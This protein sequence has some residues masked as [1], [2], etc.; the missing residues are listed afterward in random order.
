VVLGASGCTGGG[1]GPVDPPLPQSS[2]SSTASSLQRSPVASPSGTAE[3]Q[4]LSQYRRFWI[5]T[6]R[7]AFAAPSSRRA[8]VLQPVVADPLR[9]ELLRL[10]AAQ[11]RLLRTSTG[12]PRL[13]R[14]VVSRNGGEAVVFGCL[15]MSGVVVVDRRTSK[16]VA[17]G[18]SKGVTNTYFRRGADGV[19]RANA[20]NQPVGAKC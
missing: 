13:L 16:E 11:D 8:S 15:D 1:P 9:A 2:E 10:A 18:P 20:L 17:R 14:Q 12:L 6:Y 4:I 5:E 7:S 19:W 3:E